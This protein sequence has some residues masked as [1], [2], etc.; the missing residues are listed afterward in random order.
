MSRSRNW[1]FTINNPEPCDYLDLED[2]KAHANFYTYQPEKGE[3][4]T[5]HLQ[6]YV[7]LKNAKT[8]LTLKKI[9]KRAHLEVRRGSQK[10]NL[11]YCSKS[12][13]KTG[14]PVTFGEPSKQG[15][16]TDIQTYI[17]MVENGHSDYDIL[18]AMPNTY[19]K[20]P[21]LP[22]KI[23]AIL[24]QKIKSIIEYPHTW[25][26]EVLNII[27]QK[28]DQR[29]IHTYIDPRGGMGKTELCKYL[30]QHHNAFY[31]KGK[32]SD[33]LYAFSKNITKIIV[34]DI[35]RSTE[36]ISW[37]AIESLKNGLYMNTKYHSRM[38]S[39]EVPHIFLFM[40]NEPP[41]EK[42]SLDRWDIHYCHPDDDPIIIE[43]KAKKRRLE[44]LERKFID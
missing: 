33:I 22:E 3:N 17:E 15:E 41:K 25:Q 31:A 28:P 7:E 18:K 38:V 36:F 13:T 43:E 1:L 39:F 23:R 42:L 6:G 2:L 9:L 24:P 16:R 14:E 30:I 11:D 10:S 34:F 20:Y 32:S 44:Y 5:P 29:K 21:D 8:L 37:D 27:K 12:D 4:G 40:N 26:E 35:P 19:A